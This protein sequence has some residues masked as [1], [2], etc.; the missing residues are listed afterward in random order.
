ML[1][2]SACLE[3]TPFTLLK[4]DPKSLQRALYLGLFREL[5]HGRLGC[6]LQAVKDLVYARV[7]EAVLAGG[8]KAGSVFRGGVRAL[9]ATLV[10]D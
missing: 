8:V 10:V 4:Q 3:L 9:A 5:F 2:H 1:C 6:K 7:G